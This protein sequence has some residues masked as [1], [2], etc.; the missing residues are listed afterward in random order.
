MRIGLICLGIVCSANVFAN[1]WLPVQD[2]DLTIEVGSILDFSSLLPEPQPVNQAIIVKN[3]HFYRQDRLE[4]PQRFLMASLGFIPATHVLA[5]QYVKQLRLHGYNMARL[6]FIENTLMEGR[7]QDLDFDPVQLDNFHYLLSVLKQQGIYYILN[8]LSSDNAAFGNVDERWVD[9]QHAKLRVFYDLEM[10][11]HWKLLMGKMLASVNPY[12]GTS[13]LNDAALAGIIMVN[14][15]GLPY[16]TRAGLPNEL[17]SQFNQWL[18]K[19][20]H[21]NHAL[22][23]AW[24]GELHAAESLNDA[25]IDFPKADAWPSPRMSDTQAFFVE[26]EKTTAQWMLQYLRGLGYKGLL[27]AYDNWLSPAAHVSRGQ[28]EWVDLH[29]YFSEPTDFV[30]AGSIMR[31]ASLF[32]DQAKYIRELALGKHFGKAYTVSEFGQIF[33]NKYRRE[34][35]LAVPAYASFQNWDM[36]C[37][38]AVALGLSYQETDFRKD[39]IYPFTIA[40]DPIARVTE[41]L[42]SLL[43][44][45]GDVATAEHYLGVKLTP[46]FVFDEN[47]LL[48]SIPNNVSR[49][50]L[51]TGVGLDWLGELESSGWYDGQMQPNNSVMKQAGNYIEADQSVGQKLLTYTQKHLGPLG[52]RLGRSPFI[53]DEI[54]LDRLAVLHKVGVLKENNKTDSQGI[55]QTD[56]GQILMDSPKH[57]LSVVTPKTEAVVFEQFTPT[58]LGALSIVE[59]DSPALIAVSAMDG[60]TLSNSQRMLIVMATDA[61][62]SDMQFKDQA[63]TTLQ[64]LGKKPILIKSARIKLRLKNHFHAQLKVFSNTLTGKRA[65]LIKTEQEPEGISFILDTNKLAHGPTTYFEI[66]I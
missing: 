36:I 14:E 48:G 56:T 43:F 37:Q 61:R 25:S 1:Y 35:A 18:A 26:L 29:N 51:V 57:T 9:Q 23:Q 2:T 63:E 19:K 47:A 3:G 33:W 7:K 34:S 59:A 39:A 13:T 16:V 60:E 24:Q 53:A 54:W 64:E 44:L 65:E 49:L 66:S 46:E 11:N 58:N 40:Y 15:G 10:Q 17:K 32:E 21:D 42:A 22:A 30:S 50:A 27:T 41:T 38:H 5:E 52:L 31:Q 20:Y 6:D 12:T 55:F 28:F 8:G 4:K 62:N 45:R